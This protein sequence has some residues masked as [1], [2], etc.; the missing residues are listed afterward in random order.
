[1]WWSD[2]F[3]RCFVDFSFI[4]IPNSRHSST[5]YEDGITIYSYNAYSVRER[6]CFCFEQTVDDCRLWHFSNQKF[7]VCLSHLLSNTWSHMFIHK[8]TLQLLN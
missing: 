7:P 5:T 2:D 3:E 1:M 8:D 6:C 4:D